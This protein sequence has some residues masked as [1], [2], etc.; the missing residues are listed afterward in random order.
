MYVLKTLNIVLR[1]FQ[2]NRGNKLLSYR[3]V[4]YS[5]AQI[6][7]SLGLQVSTLVLNYNCTEYGFYENLNYPQL[8]IKILCAY[9]QLLVLMSV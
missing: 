7:H 9:I 1:H 6:K 8:H 2:R 3:P 5:F 4:S